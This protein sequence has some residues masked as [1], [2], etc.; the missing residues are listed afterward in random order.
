MEL[1]YEGEKHLNSKLKGIQERENEL[2]KRK[3]RKKEESKNFD[4]LY[5]EVQIIN[6]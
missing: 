2:S 5:F 6:R 1:V 3:Q 4:W